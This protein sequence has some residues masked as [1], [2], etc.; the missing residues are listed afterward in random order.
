MDK[1]DVVNKL[2]PADDLHWIDG[3]GYVMLSLEE[4][5]DIIR[6]GE[7]HEMSEDE[8]F[9]MVR[10]C[11]RVRA[12]QLLYK[13]VMSGGLRIHDFDGDDPILVR[14]ENYNA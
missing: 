7:N 12:G 1:R 3:E 2:I 9:K 10:W 4:I 11:E 5:D 6:V 13:N 8:I 14:N